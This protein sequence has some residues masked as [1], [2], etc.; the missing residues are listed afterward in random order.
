MYSLLLQVSEDGIEY[1]IHYC[2]VFIIKMIVLDGFFV[3]MESFYCGKMR[4]FFS[5]VLHV[6]KSLDN[7]SSQS[8]NPL[9]K[10][11]WC[12]FTYIGKETTFIT[13]IFRHSDIKTAYWTN[14]TL[15]KH[16]AHSTQQQDKFT[17][18]G[19]Y[20]LTCPNCGKAYV[21][22]TG[23]DLYTRF[24][25]H[26]RSFRYNSQH[27]KYAQHLIEHGHAFGNIHN[28][29]EVLQFQ[30]KGTHLNTI[31]RFHIY[32]ET[33]QNNHLNDEYTTTANKIFDTIVQHLQ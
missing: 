27:S 7:H 12:T 4:A 28:T 2:C 14:N 11:K 21:G 24:N 19:V 5:E 20:K 9:N 17:Q 25:E 16:L 8:Q 3:D 15:Q 33:I 6:Q 10:K 30:K 1:F 18:S 13:K 26:K 23:Q 29:M 22:Q 32:K 31:E